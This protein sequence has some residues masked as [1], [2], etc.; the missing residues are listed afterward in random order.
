MEPLRNAVTFTKSP[1]SYGFDQSFGTIEAT[2]GAPRGEAHGCAE[3][4][5]SLTTKIKRQVKLARSII[6]LPL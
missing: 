4:H 6:I 2:E 1:G 5:P 3:G